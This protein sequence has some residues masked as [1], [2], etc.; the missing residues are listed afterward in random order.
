[1]AKFRTKPFEIEA[2]RYVGDVYEV[3]EAFSHDPRLDFYKVEPEDA[4]D[5]PDITA[6]VF[7]Y[8]HGT[9]VGVKTGQWIIKG[10]T[11]E[12]Y[13]CDDEVFTSKYEPTS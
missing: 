9:W 12:F 1:M 10:M 2:V 3:D 5:D 8:L 11:G 6:Q 13:P 7:D 4:T